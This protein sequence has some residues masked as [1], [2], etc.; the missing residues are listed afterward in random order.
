VAELGVGR[1]NL[2]RHIKKH[3]Y[4][5]LTD[6]RT[7]YLEELRERWRLHPHLEIGK[8]DM[9]QRSDYEQLRQFE[10]DSVVF[11][12]VLEHIEDDRAVLR[13]LHE[14]VP[15]GCRVVILVPFNQKLFSD[16]DRALGHFR[17]YER[18]DWSRRFATRDSNF[19]SN[20]SSTK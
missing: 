7:D 5:L 3:E 6:Y 13:S 11:L 17:R 1:G 14:T 16:F 4:V 9:T 15:D 19:R 8:L 10:P 12:N 20:S 18:G 2:S